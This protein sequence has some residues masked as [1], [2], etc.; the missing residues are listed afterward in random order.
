MEDQWAAIDQA[1]RETGMTTLWPVCAAYRIADGRILPAASDWRLYAPQ[2]MPSLPGELAK[3]HTGKGTPIHFARRYGLLGHLQLADGRADLAG[4]PLAWIMAHARTVAAVLELLGGLGYL[5][6]PG[7]DVTADGEALA[8]I[9]RSLD[10]GPY[11]LGAQL[12]GL[13]RRDP[14]GALRD[15]DAGLIAQWGRALVVR[16]GDSIAAAAQLVEQL[17]NGNLEGMNLSIAWSDTQGF[18]GRF[19]F[20]ALAPVVYWHLANVAMAAGQESRC[21]VRHRVRKSRKGG[22]P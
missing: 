14:A 3:L 21:A 7:D 15:E 2:G 22:E 12:V 9:L 18:T 16:P 13:D 10:V 4:E 1:L 11:A 19:G 8:R 17:V 20:N 5:A 6:A